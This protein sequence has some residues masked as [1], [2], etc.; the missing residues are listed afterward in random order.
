MKVEFNTVLKAVKA[1]FPRSPEHVQRFWAGCARDAAKTGGSVE[2]FIAEMKALQSKSRAA[3]K[4]LRDAL[5]SKFGSG[6]YRITATDLVEVYGEMPNTNRTGWYYYGSR[7][8]A[9]QRL[10]LS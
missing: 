10:N 1:A 3:D 2:G 5:R 9:A 7:E 4:A 6:R 8:D